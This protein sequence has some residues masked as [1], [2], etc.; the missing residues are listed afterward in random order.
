MFMHCILVL[1]GGQ[2]SLKNTLQLGT[3]CFVMV[4]I[5]SRYYTLKIEKLYQW[6]TT[7]MNIANSIFVNNSAS[8]NGGGIQVEATPNIGDYV[9]IFLQNCNFTHNSASGD[10]GAISRQMGQDDVFNWMTVTTLKDC[11]FIENEAGYGGAISASVVTEISSHDNI[12]VQKSAFRMIDCNID[13]NQATINGGGIYLSYSNFHVLDSVIQNNNAFS[14]GGGIFIYTSQF[15][16]LNTIWT[17]NSASNSGGGLIFESPDNDTKIAR[18]YNLH[19]IGLYL[20]TFSHNSATIGGGMYLYLQVSTDYTSETCVRANWDSVSFNNN[21][22][23]TGVDAYVDG[24]EV[25]SI[26]DPSSVDRYL[27]N[28]VNCEELSGTL[29][30]LCVQTYIMGIGQ[31]DKIAMD[32][33]STVE[34]KFG[35]IYNLSVIKQKSSTSYVIF[36]V[37][38][39]DSFGNLKNADE[40]NVE[41]GEYG[42]NY[43]PIPWSATWT[44][45]QTL[46]NSST[47]YV[48]L[49]LATEIESQSSVYVQGSSPF[50]NTILIDLVFDC[51]DGSDYTK[52]SD[53]DPLGTCNPCEYGSYAMKHS[54]QKQEKWTTAL[55]EN[56]VIISYGCYAKETQDG[57]LVTAKCATGFCCNRKNGCDFVTQPSYHCAAGRDSSI[58][59]CGQCKIGL[60][61]ISSIFDSK[62]CKLC[63]D[64]ES[65]GLV[66]II[67]CSMFV[68]IILV[69]LMWNYNSNALG[70]R[71][72]MKIQLRTIIQCGNRISNI[73]I[74]ANQIL[75]YVFQTMLLFY[76]FIPFLIIQSNIDLFKPICKIFSLNIDIFSQIVS[77]FNGGMSDRYIDVCIMQELGARTKIM[78]DIIP[79]ACIL[80]LLLIL[81]SFSVLIRFM[82]RYRIKRLYINAKNDYTNDY[83]H[84][85]FKLML[86]M[87]KVTQRVT[88]QLLVFLYIPLTAIF[89]K[90]SLCQKFGGYDIATDFYMVWA[91]DTKCYESGH[92]LAFVGLFCCFL[93]PFIL[94]HIFS[95]EQT[96]DHEGLKQKYGGLVAAYK[97]DYWWYSCWN[98]LARFI[99]AVC[100]IMM[101]VGLNIDDSIVNV[102][103]AIWVSFMFYLQIQLK[104]MYKHL[105]NIGEML[106]SLIAVIIIVMD[107]NGESFI[108]CFLLILPLTPV[109]ILCVLLVL[110]CY[111][112]CIHNSTGIFKHKCGI[113]VTISQID[114]FDVFDYD[115]K[116]SIHRDK[117]FEAVLPIQF[118][119]K[120]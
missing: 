37:Y 29:T 33:N 5:T 70:I 10:G 23:K 94:F 3:Y 116:I 85:R 46:E 62:E 92:I 48:F 31:C 119:E 112:R 32:L 72:R 103:T 117:E 78:L 53:H 44:H 39:W 7:V 24:P 13:N 79:I 26:L 50:A 108:T 59:F 45:P 51:G 15:T 2:I 101:P 109:F 82:A 66:W 57:Y 80:I 52:T 47:V 88:I 71:W 19:C 42:S 6:P 102:V 34:E 4:Q 64:E 76:Q 113:N 61:E 69:K 73:I 87:N 120:Q 74:D 110:Y 67:A 98:L 41:I 75:F 11:N 106:I 115:E 95:L 12:F 22:A 91:G 17:F 111:G 38:G 118:E 9:C 14:D 8:I 63:T 86:G 105:N 97:R 89:A 114:V 55:G 104:P 100:G 35:N 16:T 93:F 60:S 68:A 90:L 65:I 49:Y 36:Q 43:N 18:S 28:F 81:N 25:H 54:C 20:S 30:Y 56:N 58:P 1:L 96:H 40:Y 99:A 83:I 77:I 27:C 107:I 21:S 84:N